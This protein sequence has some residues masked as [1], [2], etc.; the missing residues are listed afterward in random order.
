MRT[1]PSLKPQPQAGPANPFDSTTTSPRH[2]DWVRREYGPNA[3]A[4]RLDINRARAQDGIRNNPWLQ[5]ALELLVSHEI[6]CGIQPRPKIDDAGLRKELIEDWNEWVPN[7]DADGINDFYGM[8]T[9]LSHARRESGEVFVRLRQRRADDGL[10]VPLQI[11]LLESAL[12]PQGHSTLWE[13]NSIRQGIE[14]SPIGK[15]LAYWSYRT[16]PNDD[17]L[18]NP[19]I[20]PSELIRIPAAELLHHY[21]PKR[22]GQIRGI[23]HPVTA[24]LRARNFDA[25]ESAELTRKRSRAKFTGAIW[26]EDKDEN[27]V[28]DS[29]PRTVTESQQYWDEQHQI[30]QHSR[31]Y[32]DLEDGYLLNLGQAERAELFSGDTGGAGAEEF[33]KMQLRAIAAGMQVPYEILTGD[34]ANTNDRVMKVILNVFYRRLEVAQDQMIAQVLQ[35]I[36]RAWMNAKKFT[37]GAAYRNALEKMRYPYRCEWRT[38]AWAYPNMLQEAQTTLLKIKGGITSRRAAVAESGWD[39]EDVDADN[40]ADH[41][42]ERD[43]GLTYGASAPAADSTDAPE[44]P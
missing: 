23:P 40:A 26:R 43:L 28:T 25:Y 24:L 38:H 27:P 1:L 5:Y 6:G 4:G 22:P 2:E 44:T 39:V 3:A 11:Q 33:L 19:T 32:V 12:I 14:F 8:Q 15:R 34:Y 18:F 16:H 37:S 41:Q 10:N 42:R 29:T 20:N 36:W 7:A 35:P 17:L 30:Q 9:L 13:K 21:T 31:T